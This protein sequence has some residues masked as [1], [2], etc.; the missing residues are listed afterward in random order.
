[1]RFSLYERILR[2][3]LFALDPETAHHFALFCLRFPGFRSLLSQPAGSPKARRV[4]GLKFPNP[5]GLAAGFDKNA[6][7]LP[8]WEALGF[9]FVEAGTITSLGQ[10]GNPR[11]RI[12]RIPEKEALI[13]R[14]GFNNDGAKRVAERLRAL[15]ASGR[16]P[17]IPVG[18]NIGKAKVTPVEEAPAD[19][20][21]SFEKLFPYA[22]YFVLNVS[23]PNTPGLRM[24]QHAKALD[25]L[26]DAV[27]S[28]NFSQSLPKPVLVKIAPDLDFPQI[29][30]ILDVALRRRVAG[31]VATNTTV[32]QSAIAESQ[33]REGGLSGAPLRAKST[34]IVRFVASKVS[35]PIIAAGGIRD[36]DSAREKLDAGA[37]LLQIYTGF[38]YRGPALINEIRAIQ[39]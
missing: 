18:L 21:F 22:D 3:A 29:E 13:N 2:P 38:I 26:L 36:A 31:I 37:S 32:D 35:L 33:R 5:V 1:M 19:Y 4:F 24:L 34:A 16:W 6:V 30:E 9:G 8:A 25:E 15:K 20:L 11:P 39:G 23:S 10:P 7:A 14:L 27:Q 17:R 28:S 12:F